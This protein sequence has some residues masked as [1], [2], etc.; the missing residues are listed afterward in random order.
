MDPNARWKRC[1]YRERWTVWFEARQNE[2]MRYAC[3]Q[4]DRTFHEKGDADA[5][6]F[7]TG[8]RVELQ[9]GSTYWGAH[10]VAV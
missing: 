10:L 3:K 2:K 8:H 4:C 6:K 7:A 9:T 1:K 5:H